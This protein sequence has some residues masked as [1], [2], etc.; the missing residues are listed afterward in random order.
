[1]LKK[2]L[3]ITRRATLA[4]LP[5]LSAYRPF[6]GPISVGMSTVRAVTCTHQM[7]KNIREGN[8]K[9]GVFHLVHAALAVTAV[10]I[11]FFNPVFCFLFSSVSDLMINYRTCIE[12]IQTE[13]YLG[14]ARALAF[15]TLDLLFIIA[16]CHGSPALTVTCMLFQIALDFYQLVN[17]FKKGEYLEGISRTFLTG[18]HMHQSIPRLQSVF[19]S[20]PKPKKNSLTAQPQYTRMSVYEARQLLTAKY[21]WKAAHEWDTVYNFRENASSTHVSQINHKHF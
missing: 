18:I 7:I 6:Y 1:M 4:A 17:H 13:D 21:A 5:I 16:L 8:Y 3:S 15:M 14:A 12:C 20:P 11:F 19:Q 9:E 2:S 10:G